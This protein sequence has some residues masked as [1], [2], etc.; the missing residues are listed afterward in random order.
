MRIIFNYQYFWVSGVNYLLWACKFQRISTFETL[1]R[2]NRGPC[3]SP[4]HLAHLQITCGEGRG[5]LKQIS[6][7]HNVIFALS[8]PNSSQN[9]HSDNK[10]MGTVTNPFTMQSLFFFSL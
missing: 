3:S 4:K 9:C 2:Q 8:I 5:G 7:D 10:L 1:E 6:I